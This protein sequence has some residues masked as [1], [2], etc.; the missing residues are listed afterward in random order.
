MEQVRQNAQRIVDENGI[1]IEFIRKLR[2]FRKDDRI[3]KIISET[4]KK[5]GSTIASGS[6]EPG[7]NN[8]WVI[9]TKCTISHLRSIVA[10]MQGTYKYFPTAYGK[11]GRIFQR[12]RGLPIVPSS[13][14][15][16]HALHKLK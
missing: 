8:T 4:G 12:R 11:E 1:E 3:Q 6:L 2:A 15:F 9:T 14:W 7:S 16:P 10:Q 5:S 13:G